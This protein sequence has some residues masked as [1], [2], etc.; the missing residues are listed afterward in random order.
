MAD[1]EREEKLER[2]RKEVENLENV[3][4]VGYDPETGEYVTLVTE[5]K[6]E[7]DLPEDQL[8]ANNTTLSEDEHGV[9]EIGYLR[10]HS[11]SIDTSERLR[12]VPVGAEEQPDDE[13][14]VGTG[15]FIASVTD[16]S[17]GE[18]ASDVSKGDV[19]RL[20]NWHVYVG[21]SFDP[22]RPI[23]QP[24]RG[25]KVG[26]LVGS[27]PL[28]DGVKVDAAARSVS[29]EDG[30]EIRGLETATDGTEYGRSVVPNVTEEHSRATVTKSGRTTDVTTA[31]IQQI[32]ASLR[33]DY[34]TED[35]PKL[36]RLDDCV[37]TTDLGDSGDSGSPV[38]L[39]ENGALCG[40]YFAGSPTA[41]VFCQI[42]NVE[43]ALGVRAITDWDPDIPPID[44]GNG[45][46]Q[47]FKDDLIR[48]IENWPA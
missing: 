26:G 35:D 46:L 4:G 40:L 10:A 30:W 16:S 7:D 43:E 48:Y 31:E 44:H 9:E 20:S 25:E 36:I 27:V 29:A 39:Q 21:D 5:K 24:F 1:S 6:P 8:V 22:H 38:Y 3:V 13:R 2:F 47:E 17:K 45:D 37:V 23:H 12:P 41:G 19:V 32:N 34:G 15:G 14:W 11:L 33:I 42:G 28:E 18:W